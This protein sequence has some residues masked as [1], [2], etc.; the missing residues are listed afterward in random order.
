MELQNL[1]SDL[2]LLYNEAKENFKACI[3]DEDNGFLKDE[4]SISLDE[5]VVVEKDIKIVF[6]KRVFDEYVIEIC[7]ILLGGSRE[8]GK[9]T[10]IMNEKRE[11]IDD[12]LVFY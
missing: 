10:Y 11:G 5:I 1:E 7:L 8:I 3:Q 2:S 9:Y 6:S 12:S 4:L